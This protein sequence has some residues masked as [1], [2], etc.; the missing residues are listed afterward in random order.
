ML[1]DKS[2]SPPNVSIAWLSIWPAFFN[3]KISW[4]ICWQFVI[5]IGL[6]AFVRII[7]LISLILIVIRYEDF[8]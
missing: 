6:L 4:V 8:I 5:M 2:P 3:E 7:A 1:A